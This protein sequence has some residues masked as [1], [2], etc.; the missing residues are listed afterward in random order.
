MQRSKTK[1]DLVLLKTTMMPHLVLM[2]MSI[3]IIFGYDLA[4]SDEF[5]GASLD[6]EVYTFEIGDGCPNLCGW[7]NEELQNYTE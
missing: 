6:P 2:G 4:W 1:M 7:G 3:R 5:D